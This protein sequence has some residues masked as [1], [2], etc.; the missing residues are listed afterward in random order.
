MPS[1]GPRARAVPPCELTVGR[2][3]LGRICNFR[4][5]HPRSN[6]ATALG[7][8]QSHMGPQ[9]AKQGMRSYVGAARTWL[10]RVRKLPPHPLPQE[11]AQLRT[12]IEGEM[13]VFQLSV[14]TLKSTMTGGKPWSTGESRMNA[15]Q[16]RTP[17]FMLDCVEGL[18]WG[19][20]Y[21]AFPPINVPMVQEFYGNFS[22]DYQTHVFLRG[23]WIPFSK[24]DIRRYLGIT[25]D[26]PPLGEDNM[27]KAIVA[28]RKRG[29]LDMDLVFHVI[30]RQGTNWAN[31]P[32]DNTIP[33]RKIDNAI[34]NAQAIA[35]HKLIIANIDPKQHGTTFDLDHAILIYVLMI[36]G[37]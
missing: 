35:W 36:E 2:V 18:G 28:N 6:R 11:A 34:L 22:A 19:F 23:R 12:P 10:V 3:A 21:N 33:E 25:I 1:H 24:D 8:K 5:T 7:P 32:A 27:F 4:R 13:M 14:L 26:L 16:L 15:A 20:M 37:L 30:G 29:E 17:D 9:I 31:N